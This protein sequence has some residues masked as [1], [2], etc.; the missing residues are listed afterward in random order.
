MEVV[1]AL[2]AGSGGSAYA[3]T[4]TNGGRGATAET[5]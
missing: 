1:A 5:G 3:G 4:R 2:R